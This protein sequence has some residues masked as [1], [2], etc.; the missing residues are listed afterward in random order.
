MRSAT[1]STTLTVGAAAA[2]TGPYTSTSLVADIAGTSALTVDP[3]LVNPW[4]VAFA[5]NAPVWIANN[6][7]STSTLYDGSGNPQ[8]AASPLVVKFTANA[9]HALCSDRYR[10]EHDE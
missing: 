2:G 8:P 3:N 1:K 5:P 7:T 6:G 4:G 9:G 10:C